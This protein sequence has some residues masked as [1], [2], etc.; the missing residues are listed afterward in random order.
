PLLVGLFCGKRVSE[1]TNGYRAMRVSVLDDPR[2][3]LDQAWLDGYELEVYLLMK[4]IKLG[5]R[6]AEVP[7]SKVYP[8]RAIG[9]TKMRPLIDWWNMLRPIFIVG[10]GLDRLIYAGIQ[11]D[12]HRSP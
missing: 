4:L 2:I 8:P 10:F 12:V 7:V 3:D 9:N 11:R 1:S 6:T 5:Y